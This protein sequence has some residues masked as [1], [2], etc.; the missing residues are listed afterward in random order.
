M[1]KKLTTKHKEILRRLVVGEDPKAIEQ[2]LNVSAA[3]INNLQRNDPLFMSE[4]E[5]LERRA[6]DRITDS[7]ERLSVIDK[8]EKGAH[9]AIDFCRGVIRGEE[10]DTSVELKLKSAWDV[11][12]RAG[13]KPTEKKAIGVFNAADMII[14]AYN[15]KKERMANSG[16]IQEH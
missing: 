2:E 1:L 16:K 7:M 10:S 3:T 8:L 5:V 13:H 6:N 4:L 12:D 15:S 11:M 14:A 9:E